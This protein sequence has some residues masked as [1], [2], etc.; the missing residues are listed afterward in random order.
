MFGTRG[1]GRAGPRFRAVGGW[2]TPMSS[3]LVFF[4]V[5]GHRTLLISHGTGPDVSQAGTFVW[6][7]ALLV[8]SRIALTHRDTAFVCYTERFVFFPRMCDRNGGR[9]LRQWLIEQIDCG[10]Y[11]GL[12]WENDEKTMFR[13]PWKHAGKQDYNQ[14]VDASI[15]K[16][17]APRVPTRWFLVSL[18]LWKLCRNVLMIKQL[19]IS[20]ETGSA[21]WFWRVPSRGPEQLSCLPCSPCFGVLPRYTK[22][23]LQSLL[24]QSVTPKHAGT[25]YE[26]DRLLQLLLGQVRG[27]S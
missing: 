2:G 1:Q 20:R 4:W 23:R 5:L 12:I 25:S 3:L 8:S 10:M 24:F 18:W 19:S 15:F 14:E 26:G 9:R 6:T 11:P 27:A 13:I 16:V 7:S 22:G 21:A 17:K